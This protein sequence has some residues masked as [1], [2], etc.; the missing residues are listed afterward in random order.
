MQG[1]DMAVDLDSQLLEELRSGVR[2]SLPEIAQIQDD[3]LREKVVEV[4]A[5]ALAETRFKRIEDIP[6]SGVPDGPSMK[7]G[8]QADHYR[9]VATM[10]LGMARGMQ[11][12]LPHVEIDDDILLAAA[13][14][15][16]VGKAYEYEHW[17]RWEQ[18][19][20]RTGSPSLRH[21]AYGAHLALVVG[22]PE[23]VVHCVAVHSYMAEGSFVRASLETTIVQYADAA[24]WTVLS[25]GGHME[26]EVDIVAVNRR[27]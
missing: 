8:T 24:F 4:H 3:D 25:A 21:P 7:K 16:D 22:L 20:A 13:L 18:D 6:P 11:E 17:D 23:P 15:H 14:T 12:V 5:R 26:S 9:G 2:E 27:G 10:A 1:E 19:R